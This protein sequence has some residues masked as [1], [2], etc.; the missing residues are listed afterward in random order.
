MYFSQFIDWTG[1]LVWNDAVITPSE[2]EFAIGSEATWTQS[3]FVKLG[4]PRF[5]DKV[6][7]FGNSWISTQLENPIYRQL[8]PWCPNS[9]RGV[10]SWKAGA[11][12]WGG[13]TPSMWGLRSEDGPVLRTL[14][15]CL[16]YYD[17]C[18]RDSRMMLL[19]LRC[20]VNW[21][22]IFP[23][24]KGNITQQGSTNCSILQS[25]MGEH[26]KHEE[27]GKDGK[28]QPDD[29]KHFCSIYMIQNTP[30][31]TQNT[32]FVTR[33]LKTLSFAAL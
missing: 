9:V 12:W 22:S 26:R 2:S 25:W 21:S 8:V 28:H 6:K 15:Y 3:I 18:D 17:D 11:G 31:V 33:W 19:I 27:H 24:Q 16:R 7:T 32:V 14:G 29:L 20:F 10:P 1:V 30:I 13:P 23:V 5:S 4:A